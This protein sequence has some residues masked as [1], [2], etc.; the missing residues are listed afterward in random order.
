MSVGR[1][2]SGGG[3]KNEKVARYRGELIIEINA[4]LD[5]RI[6]LVSD[7][8]GIRLAQ[9]EAA[10]FFPKCSRQVLARF[11]ADSFGTIPA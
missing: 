10:F 3:S 7:A 8:A 4:K 5:A 1:H 6:L 2:Y 11:F 9:S